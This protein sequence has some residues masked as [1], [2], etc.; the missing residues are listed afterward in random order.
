MSGST[1]SPTGIVR[2]PLRAECYLP[3]LPAGGPEDRAVSDP[4]PISHVRDTSGS[5]S[6]ATRFF[7]LRMRGAMVY[8]EELPN[9][10]LGSWVRSMWYCQTSRVSHHHERVLQNVCTQVILNFSRS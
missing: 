5:M 1:I 3:Q 9:P 6:R 2:N 4:K 8:L 7:C 10:N